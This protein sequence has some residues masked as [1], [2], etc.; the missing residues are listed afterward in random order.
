MRVLQG[1]ALRIFGQACA[2][3]AFNRY[4]DPRAKTL[5]VELV[6]EFEDTLDW[7]ILTLHVARD[8]IDFLSEVQHRTKLEDDLLCRCELQSERTPRH[9]RRRWSV[10][11]KATRSRLQTSL[12]TS[13][14]SSREEKMDMT[15]HEGKGV[16]RLKQGQGK[17]GLTSTRNMGPEIANGFPI[18]L[19]DFLCRIH[20][21]YGCHYSKSTAMLLGR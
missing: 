3:R 6:R 19:L 21:Q 14:Y 9:G 11:G 7:R 10:P 13:I 1:Y 15:F 2:T 20:L 8:L 12:G 18:C 5:L 16:A 17:P 4:G